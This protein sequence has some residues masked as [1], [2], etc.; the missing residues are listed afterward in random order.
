MFENTRNASV[1]NRRSRRIQSWSSGLAGGG[2]ARSTSLRL[3]WTPSPLLE[4]ASPVS[5]SVL[6]DTVHHACP[7][8]NACANEVKTCDGLRVAPATDPECP[9]PEAARR[10]SSELHPPSGRRAEARRRDRSLPLARR[11]SHKPSSIRRTL[12]MCQPMLS[13]AEIA[14]CGKPRLSRPADSHAVQ[15]RWKVLPILGALRNS[16]L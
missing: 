1:S 11:P 12:V 3:V 2:S 15:H 4:S 13:H 14:A 8:G 16:R 5:L 9:L 10:T 7:T 6:A